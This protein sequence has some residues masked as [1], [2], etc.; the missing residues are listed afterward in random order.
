MWPT[1]H[2][3]AISGLVSVQSK[4]DGAPHSQ[5]WTRRS[6]DE[7]PALAAELLAHT[8][9]SVGHERP[10]GVHLCLNEAELE[11]RGARMER[12][13]A[14]AGNFGF[15]YR[16]RDHRELA[17]MLPGLGASVIGVSYTPYD[18]HA[19]PLNLLHARHEGFVENGRWYIPNTAINDAKASPGDFRI[20][21]GECRDRRAKSGSRRRA[22]Q[23]QFGAAIRSER[24][25]QTPEGPDPCH[26]AG[27]PRAAIADH[28]DPTDGRGRNHAGRQPGGCRF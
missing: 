15:D 13:Q 14:E 12:M 11:E 21:V 8:G 9:I 18:R 4:G 7:W 27:P 6:A 19:N 26:R 24:S 28:H 2:R 5:R 23:R 3:A 25:G 10:S 20:G 1:A 22:R 17:A 16:M